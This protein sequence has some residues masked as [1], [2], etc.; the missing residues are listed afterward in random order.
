MIAEMIDPLAGGS[1][2]AGA[3]LLG[4]VIYWLLFH[5]VPS[6]V[7]TFEKALDKVIQHCKEELQHIAK[8][9]GK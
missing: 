4:L 7:K 1:G 8:N 6:L 9:G 3:G 2:W 5:H